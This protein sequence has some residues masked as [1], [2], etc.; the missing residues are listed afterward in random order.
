ML[1]SLCHK[2][3]GM[4]RAGSEAWKQPDFRSLAVTPPG[5]LF[6]GLGFQFFTSKKE[7]IHFLLW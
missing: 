1:A 2:G 4:H 6:N 3:S 7:N 5:K